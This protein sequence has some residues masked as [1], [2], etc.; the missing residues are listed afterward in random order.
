[1]LT[2][3]SATTDEGIEWEYAH[4]PA[5]PPARYS[6]VRAYLYRVRSDFYDPNSWDPNIIKNGR[7]V[8]SV[9]NP[10]GVLLSPAQVQRLITAISQ[11]PDHRN[12]Q[13]IFTT[14][15]CA[16]DPH[17]AFVFYDADGKM[18][19]T[20]EVCTLCGDVDVFPERKDSYKYDFTAIEPLITELGLPVFHDDKD[21][22]SYR[23]SHAL[24]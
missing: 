21:V 2:G 17:N 3:C 10:E 9:A 8:K 12:G 18:A 20:V 13:L 5:W 24:H 16:F 22:T 23:A 1:M 19:A 4:A 15:N 6:T 11:T 14:N 7:L